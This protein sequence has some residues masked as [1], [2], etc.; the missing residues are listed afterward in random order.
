[1]PIEVLPYTKERIDDALLFERSIREE[2]DVWGW[3]IDEQYVKDVKASFDHP[4]AKRNLS[5]LAYVEGKPVGRID[6]SVFQTHFDGKDKAYLD[7]IC[8]L[9]SARHQGVAQ[10]LLETLRQA[11]KEKGVDTLI[12]LTAN[13]EEAQ[14]FY[15]SIPDSSMHDVGIWIDIK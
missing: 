15:R 12:A 13:N 6:A 1:M 9:K 14:R 10:A 8:V 11:L 2:E 3:E 5:Y 7:W 4:D